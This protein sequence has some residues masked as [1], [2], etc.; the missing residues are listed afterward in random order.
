MIHSG[1][2]SDLEKKWYR[3]KRK[4]QEEVI[5]CKNHHYYLLDL[6]EVTQLIWA[7][8]GWGWNLN[9]GFWVPAQGSTQQQAGCLESP[10]PSKQ[11][12]VGGPSRLILA[13]CLVHDKVSTGTQR[14]KKKKDNVEGF[15]MKFYLFNIK[16]WPW[17]WDHV[18]PFLFFL[19]D[20]ILL[21]MKL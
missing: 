3:L 1:A 12:I 2:P 8:Q 20:N 17:L 21:V 13:Q 14:S 5:A 9:P 19:N 4:S 7:S 6:S 18:C 11:G 16:A 15:V 10:H